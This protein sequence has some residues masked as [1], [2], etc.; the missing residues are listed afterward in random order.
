MVNK[1]QTKKKVKK[2]PKKKSV[3]DSVNKLEKQ[4]KNALTG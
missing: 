1:T 3:W 4:F 2:K